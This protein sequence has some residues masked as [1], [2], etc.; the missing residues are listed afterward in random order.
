MESKPKIEVDRII[1]QETKRRRRDY[2]C[3]TCKVDQLNEAAYQAHLK[4]HP[5]ECLTCGKCF[6]RRANLAL[7]LKTHLG[8][9]NFK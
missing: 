2:T 5:L 3:S 1:K 9:K 6:Y 8:I 7:H 4:I